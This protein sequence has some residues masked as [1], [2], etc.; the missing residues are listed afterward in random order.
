MCVSV[1]E[2]ERSRENLRQE[3]FSLM[4]FKDLYLVTLLEWVFLVSSGVLS[5]NLSMILA[6]R[7]KL[8]STMSTANQRHRCVLDKQI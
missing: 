1:W 8:K 7:S 2:E 5:V 3:K 4:V 6:Y